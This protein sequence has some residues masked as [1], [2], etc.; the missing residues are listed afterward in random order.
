MAKNSEVVEK[1]ERFGERYTCVGSTQ[2]AGN[3]E[4]QSFVRRI[5]H[6]KLCRNVSRCRHVLAGKS[7]RST[8]RQ[9]FAVRVATRPDFEDIVPRPDGLSILSRFLT[10]CD[11]LN[12]FI[13]GYPTQSRATSPSTARL[14]DAASIMG[15]DS[16]GGFFTDE[17]FE[18]YSVVK[19]ILPQVEQKQ[20]VDKKWVQ[21][22]KVAKEQKLNALFSVVSRALSIP[23]SNAYVE[24]VFSLM[25][26]KWS[27]VR[28]RCSVD[29]IK[30]ELL[31]SLNIHMSCSDFINEYKNDVELLKAAR[32]NKK[33][34]WKN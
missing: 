5:V 4:R 7:R 34:V 8:R 9:I 1:K 31:I 28:N 30:A 11:R 16:E 2:F 33:Y 18:D 22:F 20:S 27:N 29:L 21:V 15:F 10:I 13:Y 17:L 3:S 24:R 14:C 32:N 6:S 26:M 25:T 23:L 12:Q 19:N